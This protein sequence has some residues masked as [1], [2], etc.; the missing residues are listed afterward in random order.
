[1]D[2]TA[3]ATAVALV[4]IIEGLMPLLAPAAYK[5]RLLE[6]LSLSERALRSIGFA[7]VLVGLIALNWLR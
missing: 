2:W 7:L 6:L 5:R 1:M 4:A 3:L